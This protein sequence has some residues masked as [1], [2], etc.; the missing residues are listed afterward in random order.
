MLAVAGERYP[1]S[2]AVAMSALGAAGMITVGFVA[3]QMIGAQQ[4]ESMNAALEGD[5]PATYERYSDGAQSEFLGYASR[6]LNPGLQQA[7]MDGKLDDALAVIDAREGVSD[8]EK[9]TEK[10]G[11]QTEFESD[12]TAVVNAFNAGSRKALTLTARIPFAMGIGFLILAIYYKSI[13]GYKVLRLD[14]SGNVVTDDAPET[15]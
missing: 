3:G 6:E 9:A 14:E 5:A 4:S 10:E 12:S 11:L 13:G 1:Q 8:E 2:G 7:A 15:A